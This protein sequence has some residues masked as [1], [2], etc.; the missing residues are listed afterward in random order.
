MSKMIV[1]WWPR[2]SWP[3]VPAL[4]IYLVLASS[5]ALRTP[6]WQVPDE[7]AHFNY[8]RS[9]VDQ[10]ALPVLKPGDYDQDYLERLKS[11]R[12]PSD[13]SIDGVRY[14]SHQPPLYYS[15]VAPVYALVRDAAPQTQVYA[16]RL[17]TV[18]IGI[19]LLVLAFALVRTIFPGDNLLAL[20]V[21]AIVAAVPQHL[22]M[23]AAVNNDILSEIVMTAVLLGLVRLILFWTSPAGYVASA[24]G[25]GREV[26][27]ARWSERPAV[28]GMGLG[29]LIGLVLLTKTTAYGSLPLVVAALV[30]LIW[31]RRHTGRDWRPIVEVGIVAA[32]VA[33]VVAGWWF[34]RNA[35]VYGPMDVTGLG[36]HAEVVVGQPRTGALG[37]SGVAQLAMTLFH[38]F[39]VQ[40][41]W[42]AVPAED[43]VYGA[44][45]VVSLLAALG[46]LL[47]LL[48]LRRHSVLPARRQKAVLLLL[49]GAVLVTVGEL[50]YYNLT[51]LQ[52]QGR[53]LFPALV[54]LIIFFVLGLRELLAARH[55]QITFALLIVALLLL[56]VWALHKYLP[57]LAR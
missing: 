16:L 52:P 19:L 12:F 34:V 27:S 40:L 24:T 15:L 2:T 13:M 28:Q 6:L 22:A 3:I 45:L 18:A 25:T 42:M 9:L 17:A 31:W 53:Y 20:T 8:V 1:S 37:L 57:Y 23:T 29:V 48:G 44:L 49:A 7:P 26:E 30:G 50:A 38:S 41:G 35:A 54:P 56:D 5:F 10:G 4:L 55:T 46:T 43:S 11:A 47:Y 32:C 39:W 21:P 36:R 51:F 33:V 14:E